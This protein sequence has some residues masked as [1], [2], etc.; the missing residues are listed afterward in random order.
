V[1]SA[2]RS[3][4]T[5]AGAA[6]PNVRAILTDDQRWDALGVLQREQGERALFPYTPNVR[7]VRTDDWKYVHYPNGDGSPDR[8]LAELYHVKEDPLERRNLVNRPEAKPKLEELRAE[9]DKN[10]RDTGALPD[11]MPASPELKME[12]PDAKIR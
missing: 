3:G 7:G 8:Y 9:L 12:L 1:V 6:R 5:F 11:R 2:L 10:L 4:A